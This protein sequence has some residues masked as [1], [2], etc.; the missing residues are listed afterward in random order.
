MKKFMNKSTIAAIAAAILILAVLCMCTAGCVNMA[1]S[2]PV[3]GDWVAEDDTSV[4][5][6]I[7]EADGSGYFTAAA[8]KG[9]AAGVAAA[10]FDW[11][12]VEQK[13]TY[14]L[15]LADGTTK[16]ASLNVERGILTIDGVEYQEALDKFS[17]AT[18]QKATTTQEEP[19]DLT[20]KHVQDGKYGKK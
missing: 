14:E 17:G 9:G 15:V 3:V 7:F 6:V 1:V 2:D 4:T 20:N 12:A 19:Q 8:E 16:T 10:T 18:T 13:K 11:T 5:H